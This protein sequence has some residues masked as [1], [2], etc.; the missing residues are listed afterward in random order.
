MRS[1]I[2]LLLSAAA[3]LAAPTHQAANNPELGV[4]KKTGGDAVN[5]RQLDTLLPVVGSVVGS[6]LPVMDSV[7][8]VAKGLLAPAAAA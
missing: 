2:V 5:A 4:Y 6:V 3:V 7:L 8:S 1:A